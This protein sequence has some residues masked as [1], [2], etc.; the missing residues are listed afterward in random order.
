VTL[1]DLFT[2]LSQ[3][4]C[5]IKSVRLYGESELKKGTGPGATRTAPDAQ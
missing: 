3:T 1:V 2:L 4:C 5:S